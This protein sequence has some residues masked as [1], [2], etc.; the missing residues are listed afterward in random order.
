MFWNQGNVR[1]LTLFLDFDAMLV[2]FSR[3]Q[4]SDLFLLSLYFYKVW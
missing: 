4:F 3:L 2:P 1:I